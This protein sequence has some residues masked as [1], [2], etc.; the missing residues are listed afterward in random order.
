MLAAGQVSGRETE[1]VR[2]IMARSGISYDIELFPWKR[3]YNLALARPD[4][5]VYSTSRTPE[6][7]KLFKWIGPLD[8][9][10]W[11]LYGRA[12]RT[13][14]L[15]T[16]EDARGLRIGTYLG[17]V[18]DEYL[19]SRGFNVD[20]VQDD[21]ANPKKLLT[22]RI[23]LW[24]VGRRLGGS[25]IDNADW[26]KQIVPLLTFSRIDV[27]LACNPALPDAL[28]GKMNGALAALRR[29]GSFEQIDRKYANWRAP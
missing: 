4:A 2:Q 21:A 9:A 25:T 13:F 16:L 19:R 12:D 10:A 23:D 7:E 22:N 14:K 26:S 17:D 8:Q 6:R 5:C 27:Y 15:D 1:K 28:I 18:R 24:A 11:V 29:E 20:A 3:A